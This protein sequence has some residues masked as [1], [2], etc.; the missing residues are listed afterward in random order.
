MEKEENFCIVG[1]NADSC[2]HCGKQYGEIPQKIKNGSSFWSNDPNCGN[3]SEGTQNTNLKEHNHPYVHFSVIYNHQD[4]ET[5]QVSINRQEHKTTMGHLQN[6]AI[7]L[8]CTK[9]ENYTLCNSIYGAGEHYAKWNKPVRER[10]IP[11]DFTY[12][13]NLVNKLNRENGDRLIDGEQNDS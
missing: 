6:G 1:G 7:L 13:W 8:H 3:T 9:E 2:S 4:T 11:Y 5:A 12:M 10:Q